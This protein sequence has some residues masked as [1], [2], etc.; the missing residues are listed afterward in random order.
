MMKIIEWLKHVDDRVP[1][2]RLG[3]Y[4][5]CPGIILV[6]VGALL[7]ADPA[8]YP[9]QFLVNAG[10][11]FLIPG[12]LLAIL[13]VA[14]DNQIL[15][16]RR[17]QIDYDTYQELKQSLVELLDTHPGSSQDVARDLADAVDYGK[18]NGPTG[19][20]DL[21]RARIDNADKPSI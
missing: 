20:R 10:A 17:A 21:V 7:G 1:V 2:Y 4:A 8:G 5:A 9:V 3:L 14:I 6:V 15:L 11:V 13:S 19:A 18:R 16:P 12:M